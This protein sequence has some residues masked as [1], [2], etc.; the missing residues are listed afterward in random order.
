[1]IT[2]LAE[3]EDVHPTAF[4]TVKLYVP[5]VRAEIVMLVPVPAIAPGL[6]VQ[7]PAGKLLSTTLPVATAQVGCVI[8][9]AV[10]VAGAPGAAVITTFAEAGE[11]HPEAFVT[12]KLYV[13]AGSPE[14]VVVIPVPAIA[15]GLIV[16]LP[17]GRPFSITLPVG[18]AQVGCVIVPTAGAVG[19]AGTAL[20]TTL[21]EAGEVHPAALVTEKLYVPVARPEIVVL[22]PVPGTAPGLMVQFPVGNPF[23][24]TLPVGAAQVG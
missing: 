15:P 17:A 16:Q 13:A 24:I 9:P 4:V 23:N 1:V 14:I 8:V 5:A 11:V 22:V 2:T 6:I 7:L 20:I 18:T 12:V 19:A 3:G 21:A 10:G